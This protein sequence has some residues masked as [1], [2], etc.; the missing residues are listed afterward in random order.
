M[1][2]MFWTCLGHA[3]DMFATSLGHVSGGAGTLSD[4]SKHRF[5]G[6]NERTTNCRAKMAEKMTKQKIALQKIAEQKKPVLYGDG[7]QRCTR[8]RNVR[9]VK[10][11]GEYV[12]IV[13]LDGTKHWTPYK[14]CISCRHR[15]TRRVYHG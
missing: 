2:D 14:T 1:S 11:Y 13:Y 6:S 7:S 5:S 12:D 15:D 9:H 10:E 8:C 4:I 3:W